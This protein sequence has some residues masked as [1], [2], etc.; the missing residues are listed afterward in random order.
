[1]DGLSI[2]FFIVIIIMSALTRG[3]RRY[4]GIRSYWIRGGYFG[5]QDDYGFNTIEES[6]IFFEHHVKASARRRG[7]LKRCEKFLTRTAKDVYTLKNANVTFIFDSKKKTMF[8]MNAKNIK[9]S[10]VVEWS[11]QIKSL[12]E[13]SYD[14]TFEKVFD[15]I[16]ISFDEGSN[17]GGILNVLKANFNDV[18]EILE[19]DNTPPPKNTELPAA[20]EET[21][22]DNAEKFNI[23]NISE[24]ALSKLPGINIVIAKK[25]IGRINLKGGYSS[26][27]EM[28]S[29]MKIKKHF[30]KQLNKLLCAEPV[31]YG[32]SNNTN[33]DRIID[34]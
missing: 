8:C 12:A 2:L 3:R 21:Q 33:E 29:E 25:I 31:Q 27:E 24:E 16:C 26:L 7:A 5:Q 1:M 14:N 22:I 23:N 30:Q 4:R 34:L 32:N 17:Y 6:S 13:E 28:Y 11:K 19:S 10:A 18:K 20:D 15:S 9:Q